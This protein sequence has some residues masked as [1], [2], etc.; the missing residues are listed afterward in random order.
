MHH[1]LVSLLTVMGFI[2]L[3]NSAAVV[4][5][6]YTETSLVVLFGWMIPIW[7]FAI[8]QILWARSRWDRSPARPV[9]GRFLRRAEV[10]TGVVGAWWGLCVMLAPTG[11]VGLKVSMFAIVFG[12]CA[13]VVA[14]VSPVA[15]VAARFLLGAATTATLGFFMAPLGLPATI[16]MLG[17]VLT[18]ASAFASLNGYRN[19]LL[20]MEAKR[21]AA[22]NHEQLLDAVTAIPEAFAIYDA[23]GNVIIQNAVHQRWFP[24]GLEKSDF[25]PG[26]EMRKLAD[27]GGVMRSCVPTSSGGRVI[28]HTDVSKMEDLRQEAD[29][30]RRDAE[31]A[32]LAVERFVGSVTRELRLP[33]R[34]LRTIASRFETRS[35][36]PFDDGEVRLAGD[37]MVSFA[38]Q[39]L[40]LVDEVLS[41]TQGGDS[42]VDGSDVS[43]K[44]TLSQVISQKQSAITTLGVQIDE[45]PSGQDTMIDSAKAARVLSRVFSAVLLELG[46]VSRGGGA[47]RVRCGVRGD[48]GWVSVE[49]AKLA[50]GPMSNEIT[51]DYLS[52]SSEN[53][54]V[55]RAL[56][57]TIGGQVEMREARNGSIVY[58]LKFNTNATSTKLGDAQ[59]LAAGRPHRAA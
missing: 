8:S 33:L 22:Q 50:N 12:M 31:E 51:E 4:F 55:W 9:R 44:S 54:L 48:Q 56:M 41:I 52:E 15:N 14:V 39:A 32:R 16:V 23:S 20:E 37:K 26:T 18:L 45:E 21:L 1:R 35:Q 43:L 24:K 49:A 30:S 40:S 38:D 27:V 2:N 53:R 34:T 42:I 36:I 28:I 6:L 25:R 11:D 10:A 3:V 13:G 7:V 57:Q 17:I 29:E 58:I 19:L 59:A 47:M 46:Q 5:T